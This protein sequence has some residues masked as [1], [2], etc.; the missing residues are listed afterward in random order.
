MAGNVQLIM[1]FMYSKSYPQLKSLSSPCTRPFMSLL[2]KSKQSIFSIK[3]GRLLKCQKERSSHIT[4]PQNI[5]K[6]QCVT[7]Q[8]AR[9]VETM[10]GE[11]VVSI[12][13]HSTRVQTKVSI[14]CVVHGPGLSSLLLI[15]LLPQP[16][17]P[18]RPRL[19]PPLQVMSQSQY[20]YYHTIF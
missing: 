7:G 15:T 9:S 4:K 11:V 13:K 10:G 14:V 16:L 20:C 6:Q 5:K 2:P 12:S 17:R 18:L 1:I 19:L 3:V 8:P